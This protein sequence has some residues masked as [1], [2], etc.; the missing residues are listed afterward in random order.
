M[1]ALPRRL[2]PCVALA[3]LVLLGM[4]PAWADDP[5]EEFEAIKRASLKGIES[6]DVIV[7]GTEV[8]S[9]CSPFPYDSTHTTVEA[10]MERAGIR[11]SPSPTAYLFV[12]VAAVEA[13]DGLL[14]GFAVSV[15]LQQIVRLARD[16]DITTFGTT[17]HKAG[18]GIAGTSSIPEFPQH[19]LTAL[20][21]HFIA[22]YRE[23]N[24]KPSPDIR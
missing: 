5:A 24:T 20:V 11:I 8:A 15:E 22:A 6:V 21:D 23:Q 18:L 10:R 1:C 14:C 16:P 12:S 17:W 13:L 2:G 19:M 7:L 9:G 3:L 4:A